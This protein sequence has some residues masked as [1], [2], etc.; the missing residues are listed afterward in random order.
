MT[1]G[2]GR[3]RER[4]VSMA[5]EAV[6]LVPVLVLVLAVMVAGWRIWT[7]RADVRQASHAAARS[8]SLQTSGARARVMATQVARTQLA[9]TP[10]R[11]MSI[12][13]DTSDFSRPD[14]S[15]ASVSVRIGC[16]VELGDLLLPGVP[17]SVDASA[18]GSSVLDRFRQR[19]P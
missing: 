16:S 17:G 5:V 19:R 6:L 4:G 11:Q 15:D 13:V 9:A 2:V 10:C 18:T 12:D 14:L 7:V 8:A 1:K 3:L